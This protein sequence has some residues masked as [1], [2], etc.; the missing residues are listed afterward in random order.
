MSAYERWFQSGPEIAVLRMLGLFDRPANKGEIDALR[1]SPAIPGLTDALEGLDGKTWNKALARLRRAALLAAEPGDKEENKTLDAHP[2]VREHFGEALKSAQPE[3]WRE[4]HRRLYEHL[5]GK[6]KRLPETVEEMSPLYAAVVHGC[7]AGRNQEALDDVFYKRIQRGTEVF[8]IRKLGTFGANVAVLSAF[9][10]P[11]W[12]RLTPGLTEPDQGYVL[13]AAGFA[14]RALGRLPEAAGLMRLAVEKSIA[15][16]DWKNA[17][18]QAGNLSELFLTRGELGEALT[19][20]QQSVELADKSGDAGM[21]M[22]MRTT[23]ADVLHQ[24]GRPAEAVALF[25]EAERLQK[26]RPPVYPQLHSLQ[27]F[28]YCDMLLEQGQE[29]EVLARAAQTLEWARAHFGLLANALDHLSL[30][31]AHLRPAQRGAEAD[32]PQAATHLDQAVDGLRRA[33]AQE[34]I[35]R[36]LLARAELRLLTG[37]H[38]RARAD[39]DEALSI[40]TRSGMRL[41]QT[42]AHLGY[43]RLH[44]ALPAPDPTQA[45]AHLAEARALIETTGYHRRDL[46]LAQLDA[47]HLN[48]VLS[49]PTDTSP[50]VAAAS[51]PAPSPPLTTA[52]VPTPPTQAPASP[53]PPFP[54]PAP[55]VDAYKQNKLAL[56]FGSGLSLAPD[57]QGSFPRWADLPTRLLDQVEYHAALQP[58][59]IALRRAL[60]QGYLPLEV[61]LSDLDPIKTTLRGVRKYQAALNALFRP[62]NAAPGDA[63]RALVALGVPLLATTNYDALLEAAEGRPAR[64]D[65]TWAEADKALS[66]L[67]EGRKVLFKLHGTADREETVVMTQAE[68]TRAHA[69][70]T[71]VRVLSQLLQQ[72]TFLLLGYGMNDPLDLDL[73]LGL[74]A[75]AFGSAGRTHYVLMKGASGPDRDRWLR[76]F[77][78]QV[79]DYQDHADLPAILRALGA[80]RP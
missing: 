61:M 13:N 77:N 4:G 32:L 5:R 58:D 7:R 62:A 18:I 59:Q 36:G 44:L 39:L 50:P 68:Y 25:E 66:D 60:F 23:L 6:A 30:G 12:E 22:G 15:Q 79:I 24:R 31:R 74:N 78:V 49:P 46:L 45:R 51:P 65:Y 55:L 38:P 76:T 53:T 28:R 14:L 16:E 37:D 11:P 73:V 29:A 71:Y 8:S 41:H 40:A 72:N 42:D 48:L 17:A 54:F 52:P 9:F 64:T 35:P 27:G 33:S 43:A 56:L 26:E 70:D 3:A 10:D 80:T 75:S 57:V 63:H 47:M 19:F 20:A 69:H 34:F 1:A 21:R 67:G 2:L